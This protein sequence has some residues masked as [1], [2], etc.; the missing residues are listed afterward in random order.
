LNHEPIS[1][2]A[3]GIY[4]AYPT[5]QVLKPIYRKLKTQVNSAHTKVGITTGRFS[6]REQEYMRTFNGEV[7]FVPIVAVPALQLRAIE[8]VILSEMRSRYA[9]V[10]R[11]REWFDTTEH[12]AIIQ[13]VEAIASDFLLPGTSTGRLS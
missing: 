5:T 3:T 6:T 7:R 4:I 10:G 9:P 1:R 11:A 8:H 2:S 12:E 13:L